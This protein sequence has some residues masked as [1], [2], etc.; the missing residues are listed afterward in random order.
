MNFDACHTYPATKLGTSANASDQ[1]ALLTGAVVGE[2]EDDGIVALS[3]AFKEVDEARELEI[4]V[5]EHA[6]ECRL[7][8]GEEAALV[9]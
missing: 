1:S 6:G 2:D 7:E 8:T 9:G 3:G 4:G 5:I